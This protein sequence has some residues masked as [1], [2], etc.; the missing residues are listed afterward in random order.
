MS[1]K[2]EG[3]Y[4]GAHMGVVL[5]LSSN[6][7]GPRIPHSQKTNLVTLSNNNTAS[8]LCNKDN[9]ALVME[10]NNKQNLD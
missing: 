8:C 2:K 10:V 7:I 9:P 5:A 4:G 6:A 3:R 1:V